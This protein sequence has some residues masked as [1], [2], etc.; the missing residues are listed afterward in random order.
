[1]CTAT[2]RCVELYGLR[3]ARKLRVHELALGLG[4]D[5]V[6][7]RTGL[8]RV[9]YDW[10]TPAIAATDFALRPESLDKALDFLAVL[11]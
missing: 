1:M 2:F 10:F 4:W 6:H 8:T 7:A 11:R 3:H 5:A 9:F